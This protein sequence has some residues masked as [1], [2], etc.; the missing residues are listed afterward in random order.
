MDKTQQ[1]S[2]SLIDTEMGPTPGHIVDPGH[3][4]YS[5]FKIFARSHLSQLV[6]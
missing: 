3:A 6:N 5:L 1:V 2:R 4:H